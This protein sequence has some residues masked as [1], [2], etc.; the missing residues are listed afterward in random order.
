VYRYL[1]ELHPMAVQVDTSFLTPEI[2]TAINAAGSRVYVDASGSLDVWGK[3]SY[4]VLDW[5]GVDVIETDRL[6]PAVSYAKRKRK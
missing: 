6:L 5:R 2:V 3:L 4:A 1:D